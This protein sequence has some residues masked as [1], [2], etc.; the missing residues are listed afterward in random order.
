[1][2]LGLPLWDALSADQKVA[3]LGHEFGHGVNRD[4]R[5]GLIVGTSLASLARLY[6]VLRSD[7]RLRTGATW[8]VRSG[9]AVQ[10]LLRGVIA[11]AF[12]AQQLISLRA[13][14]RAEY[15]AD[16]LGARV[17]SPDAMA[18]ALDVITTGR[19][20]FETVKEQRANRKLYPVRRDAEP[21]LWDELRSALK[22]VPDR[23]RERRRRVS[24]HALLQVTNTHPP[25]HLR[26]S[27]LRSLRQGDAPVRL[28]AAH[29]DKIRA[30]LAGDY[31]RIGA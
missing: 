5:R 25:S 30:E 17:A 4:A 26:I 10:E 7:L 12:W 11:A 27:M 1:M 31:A 28:S 6:A 2:T 13:G 20:T 16:A 14:Q 3:I 8:G 24:V 29:E 18:G 23:E 9:Q 15:L 19:D 21:S 22:A